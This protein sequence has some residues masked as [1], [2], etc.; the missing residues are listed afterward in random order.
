MN[1][2]KN[3]YEELY[4]EITKMK[5]NEAHIDAESDYK[6]NY[7]LLFEIFG[8]KSTKLFNFFMSNIFGIDKHF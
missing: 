8:K 2:K 5:K 7:S 6:L 1:E 4:G 3:F